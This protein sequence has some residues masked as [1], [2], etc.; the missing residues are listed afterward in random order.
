MKFRELLRKRKSKYDENN[1]SEIK[2]VDTLRKH[3]S[4]DRVQTFP[5]FIRKQSREIVVGTG[6]AEITQKL[7][8]CGYICGNYVPCLKNFD[9]EGNKVMV[10]N[11]EVG[12][13]CAQQILASDRFCDDQEGE[14]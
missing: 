2:M 14:V 3:I 13:S 6:F 5:D 12:E 11:E 8:K 9:L 10:E 1:G 7:V 4:M